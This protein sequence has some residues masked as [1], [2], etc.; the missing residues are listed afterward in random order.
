M[1]QKT[2]GNVKRG[3]HGAFGGVGALIMRWRT[4]WPE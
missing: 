3:G 2:Q 1:R 4:G